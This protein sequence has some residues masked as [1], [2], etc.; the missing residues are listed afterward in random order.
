MNAPEDRLG[1]KIGHCGDAR[2]TTALAPRADIHPR[3]WYVADVPRAAMSRCSNGRTQ[4]VGLLDH[5][6]GERLWNAG[7]RDYSGLMLA[8]RITLAHFSVSAV[9]WASNSAGLKGSGTVANS[10]NLALITAVMRPVLISLLSLSMIPA[11]V[12]FRVPKPAKDS[13]S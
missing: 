11:G 1:F 2:C 5:R 9:S 4:K 8:V 6:I 10:A 13:T 12:P 7:G 3:S